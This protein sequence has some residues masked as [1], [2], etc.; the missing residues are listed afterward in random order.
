[1]NYTVTF[2]LSGEKRSET[3]EAD[4]AGAGFALCLKKYPDAQ[5][6]GTTTE[7]RILKT[8]FGAIHYDPPPVQRH[9]QSLK[10][11]PHKPRKNEPY[12]SFPF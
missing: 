3:F 11:G 12:G 9:P 4:N 6:I 10:L 2:D 1:M 8:K 7:A 5:L